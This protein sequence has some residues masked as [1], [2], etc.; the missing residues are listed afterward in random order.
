[1]KITK[2]T[3]ILASRSPR[4][5]E[6]L[7]KTGLNF[8]V[9]ESGLRE[10]FD[11]K[12]AP[13]EIAE[14]LSLEKA[15]TVV[16]KF[17]NAIIISADTL[18]TIDNK[19]LGKPKDQNDAIKILGILNGKMHQVITGFTVY[20]SSTSKFVTKSISS[21]VYFNKVSEKEIINYVLSKKPLDKA[22]A[23]GIQELPKAFIKK[24]EG[25]YDNVIGLPVNA[26]LKTLEE[27]GIKTTR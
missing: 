14:K 24:I 12:L 25:D 20:D 7:K 13:H 3:V 18:V 10:C 26:L 11:P 1:M 17:K 9:T 8:R 23:Y 16:Q 22:G 21:K 2:P 15:A 27:F 6:L 4:R 19:A 5:K